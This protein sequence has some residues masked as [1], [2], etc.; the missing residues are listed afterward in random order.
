MYEDR[1]VKKTSCEALLMLMGAVP[2]SW[3]TF[4]NKRKPNLHFENYY[5]GCLENS[6]TGYQSVPG[7]DELGLNEDS[8][9]R[10]V[11]TG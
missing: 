8:T 11:K 1:G 10:V 3:K 6:E 4:Y 2:T 5:P 7:M 9:E